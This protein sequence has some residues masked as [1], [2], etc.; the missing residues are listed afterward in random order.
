MPNE[1]LARRYATAVF[2][3]AQ[4][5]G[6]TERIGSDLAAI[7]R[8]IESETATHEFFLAPTV[9]R[10]DKERA[11]L[12]VFQGKVDDVALHTLLLLVRKR[13]EALLGELLTEYRKLEQ[14]ARGADPLL[15]TTAR[16]LP[17]ADVRAMVERLERVYGKK[18]EATV[19]HDPALIGGVRITMGDRRID[20]SVAGRL[21]ELTRTL[22]ASN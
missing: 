11:L 4:E 18:F 1:S 3:L 17:D 6:A 22:F 2:S 7:A 12:A 15:V 20:G 5:N 8:A 21:E 16:E 10:R 9:D 13:R 19:K 14:A